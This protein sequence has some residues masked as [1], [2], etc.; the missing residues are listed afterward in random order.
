MMVLALLLVFVIY[1]SKLFYDVQNKNTLPGEPDNAAAVSLPQAT[2]SAETCSSPALQVIFTAPTTAMASQ[3]K[4]GPDI[5]LAAA[6]DAAQKSVDMAIYNLSLDSISNA[7]LHARERGVQVRLVMESDSLDKEKP[8]QLMGAGIPILGDRGEALMH[9][10]FTIIDNLEV[11]TGSMNYTLSG[12]YNDN[13]NLIRICSKELA[14]YYTDEFE[15]MF[16]KDL[17]GENKTSNMTFPAT[18]VDGERIEVFFAPQDKISQQLADL[19]GTAKESIH[20]LAYIFTSDPLA[21]SIAVRGEAGV[22][23]QGIFE[24]DQLNSSGNDYPRFLE[25]GYDVHLDTNPG[26]MH[27]KV[28]II[29]GEVVVTGSYNFTLSADEKNDENLL[30]IHDPQ[31]AALFE[32]EFKVIYDQAQK[33]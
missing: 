2:I 13:N 7:L 26:L 3:K 25:S 19:L 5:L 10:K 1:L 20:I 18:T 22:E 9:D 4:G 32:Q 12:A 11:W 30:I 14:Q 17:F 27:H 16:T 15:K 8:Q 23:I 24:K 31:I 28:I 33:K 29:D 6:I 21:Q